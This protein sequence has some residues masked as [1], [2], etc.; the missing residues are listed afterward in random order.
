[1]KKDEKE[2]PKIPEV[3]EWRKKPDM[4]A[5]AEA[6]KR[7]MSEIFEAAKEGDPDKLREITEKNMAEAG[8]RVDSARKMAASALSTAGLFGLSGR[9]ALY[10][11]AL[12]ASH[13]E[14]VLQLE[15]MPKEKADSIIMGAAIQAS[16]MT[17]KLDVRDKAMALLEGL[18]GMPESV[19]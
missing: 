16:M 13:I 6:N 18:Q 8:I 10:A 15:G 3:S 12:I 14:Q 2:M 19:N 7:R 11:L 17:K 5:Q 9:E 4:A 1:M